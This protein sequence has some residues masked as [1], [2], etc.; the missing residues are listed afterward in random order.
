VA[1]SFSGSGI[2]TVILSIYFYFK[3]IVALFM[4]P[5]LSPPAAPAGALA[6]RLAGG[7]VFI[8]LLLLGLF[9]DGA[10]SVI[11]QALSFWAKIP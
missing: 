1:I 7:V 11:Q 9:P 2:L 8:L 3:V 5:Y 4:K 10:F 6:D